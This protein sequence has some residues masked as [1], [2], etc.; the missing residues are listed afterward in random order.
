MNGRD[1]KMCG[2]ERRDCGLPHLWI[3]RGRAT[4]TLR[5]LWGIVLA[6]LVVALVLE[7]TLSTPTSESR[8]VSAY[9]GVS[10]PQAVQDATEPERRRGIGSLILWP[11]IWLHNNVAGFWWWV[12]G[13]VSGGISATTTFTAAFGFITDRVRKPTRPD[14]QTVHLLVTEIE[15]DHSPDVEMGQGHVRHYAHCE[16]QEFQAHRLSTYITRQTAHATDDCTENRA[17][18]ITPKGRD[19]TC[20]PCGAREGG[21][22]LRTSAGDVFGWLAWAAL[23][24]GLGCLAWF[25]TQRALAA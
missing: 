25:A 1:T 7:A 4:H 2:G 19:V 11:F 14:G 20:V 9:A 18:D 15:G 16:S 6:A 8:T 10:G 13:G 3:H 23:V 5:K 24:G 21:R 17:V 22:G 12:L